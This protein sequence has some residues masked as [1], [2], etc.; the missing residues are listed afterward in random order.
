MVRQASHFASWLAQDAIELENS[1]IQSLF[2]KSSRLEAFEHLTCS[3][4]ELS[5][6][7]WCSFS[8]KRNTR[9][10]SYPV[11]RG[12]QVKVRRKA[13]CPRRFFTVFTQ[14][15]LQICSTR[16]VREHGDRSTFHAF[17]VSPFFAP[18]TD[19]RTP[20][21]LSDKH[22]WER[23]DG[24]TLTKL[25]LRDGVLRISLQGRGRCLIKVSF[26]LLRT[27]ATILD[28]YRDEAEIRSTFDV[29]RVET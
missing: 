20:Q 28:S 19:S 27:F 14:W 10:Y 24:S 29:A 17:G 15:K 5:A 1:S 25:T 23:V 6:N 3:P 16:T 26:A 2:A 9:S 7:K 4:N 21:P 12:G 8:C 18:P 13:Q 11:S 22:D